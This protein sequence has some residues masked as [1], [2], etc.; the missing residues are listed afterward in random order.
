MKKLL[1]LFGILDL[2]SFATTIHII[3][4]DFHFHSFI[5]W[6]LIP[7]SISLIFSAIFLIKS[8][9]LGILIYYFQFPIRM[10]VMAGLSFGF[11]IYLLKLFSEDKIAHMIL[12]STMLVLEVC[13]LILTIVIHKKYFLKSS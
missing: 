8:K 2:I 5:I 11:L 4:R 1:L 3:I 12:M 9:L 13:R 7:L 6:I 10:L